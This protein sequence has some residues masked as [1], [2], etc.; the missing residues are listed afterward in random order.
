PPNRTMTS[1]I[2]GHRD[3]GGA[4]GLSSITSSNGGGDE[5]GPT[6]AGSLATRFEVAR[7]PSSGR[8]VWASG[9][10]TRS[11]GPTDGGR[12]LRPDVGRSGAIVSSAVGALAGTPPCDDG[13]I[14]VG[15]SGG[16]PLTVV[17]PAAAP[18]PRSAPLSA[19]GGSGPT[20]Y[21]GCRF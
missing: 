14:A 10:A 4:A 1:T 19:P 5:P 7:G 13:G 3:R 11:G 16:A 8:A 2:S 17:A 15:A 9:L 6:N 20:V 12:P 18:A 21:A